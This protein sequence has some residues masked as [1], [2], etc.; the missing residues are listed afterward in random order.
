PLPLLHL[1]EVVWLWGCPS[2]ACPG[3]L[4]I[5]GELAR[6][7]P[8]SLHDGPT[9]G[10]L[11]Y[12]AISPIW[13]SGSRRPLVQYLSIHSSMDTFIH[14]HIQSEALSENYMLCEA[15]GFVHRRRERQ[16]PRRHQKHR[17]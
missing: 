1:G 12:D 14:L 13:V 5:A 10:T 7:H 3:F 15:L 17:L 6:R 16:A 9:G 2:Y 11:R 8:H 4:R